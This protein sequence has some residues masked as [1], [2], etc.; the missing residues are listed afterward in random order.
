MTLNEKVFFSRKTYLTWDEVDFLDDDGKIRW[1][2][3]LYHSWSASGN[4]YHNHKGSNH[5]NYD[6]QGLL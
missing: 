4:D 3:G 2:F 5:N 1:P 6:H